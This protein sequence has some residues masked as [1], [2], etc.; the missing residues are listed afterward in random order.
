MKE[1]NL[2]L[3]ENNTAALVVFTLAAIGTALIA[4][5]GMKSFSKEVKKFMADV[6]ARV[7]E[8]ES[9]DAQEVM[10]ISK[11]ALEN[12]IL[13]LTE[14]SDEVKAKREAYLKSHKARMQEFKDAIKPASEILENTNV[15]ES[16]NA[17][18][19]SNATERLEELLKNTD[20][21]E[22]WEKITVIS[23]TKTKDYVRLH[24]EAII[25]YDSTGAPGI[26][27]ISI[28]CG[29]HPCGYGIIGPNSIEKQEDGTFKAAWTTSYTC[30]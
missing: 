29:Y 22:N 12:S 9:K 27:D 8:A 4:V 17:K 28:A 15:V 11:E 21:R 1:L 3:E 23:H 14:A 7:K 25:S 10:P 24:H 2:N 19:L 13:H 6:E 18:D 20:T 5:K 26:G 16:P 30:D